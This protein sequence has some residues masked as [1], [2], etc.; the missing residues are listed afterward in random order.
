MKTTKKEFK[1]IFFE[2]VAICVLASVIGLYYNFRNPNGVPVI[3]KETV[4]HK[5]SDADLFGDSQL[6][7]HDVEKKLP[8]EL[9]STQADNNDTNKADTITANTNSILTDTV[10]S[11]HKSNH[12]KEKEKETTNS[13][14]IAE[15]ELYEQETDE[16]GHIVANY[17]DVTYEQ[18]LRM[19]DNPD[20]LL[21]DARREENWMKAHIGNA[22]N[23]FPYDAEDI[24]MEKC[25]D[26]PE[27]K[28]I[29]VYCEGGDCDSSHMLVETLIEVIGLEKVYIY[30]G[31]W[32]DW[33]TRQ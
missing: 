9:Q 6:T 3:Y 21:I 32:D 22:I 7:T 15:E 16:E 2:I 33:V 28:K 25:F 8:E 5:T 18:V 27:D 17:T 19:I 1:K 23:I 31:G 11:T 26:L 30:T 10:A 24:V 12:E 13:K 29:V 14:D 20:F 4:I